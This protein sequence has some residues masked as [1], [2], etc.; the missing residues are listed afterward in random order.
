LEGIPGCPLKRHLYYVIYQ[1]LLSA[2]ILEIVF[3]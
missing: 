3:I 1:K 2:I